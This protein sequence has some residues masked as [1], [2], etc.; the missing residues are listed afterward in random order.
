MNRSKKSIISLVMVI[1]LVFSI[2]GGHVQATKILHYEI[3][4]T[5]EGED[6]MIWYQSDEYGNT[7]LLENAT[8]SELL[9]IAN[10]EAAYYSDSKVKVGVY[11]EYNEEGYTVN[12]D[13]Y[14]QYSALV[15]GDAFG[16][17]DENGESI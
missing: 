7:T 12:I 1:C 16:S 3:E 5:D 15:Y 4:Q 2:N 14:N 9:E 11:S 10:T 8:V 6:V 13:T 17:V